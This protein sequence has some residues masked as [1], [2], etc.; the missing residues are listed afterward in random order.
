MSHD[1]LCPIVLLR[2]RLRACVH[3]PGLRAIAAALW[4]YCQL[5]WTTDTQGPQGQPH[6]RIGT[7]TIDCRIWQKI[8]IKI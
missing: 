5:P 8:N 1:P 4:A 7:I 6:S 3:I 2:M